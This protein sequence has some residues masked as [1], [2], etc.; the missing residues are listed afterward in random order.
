MFDAEAETTPARV[1]RQV[2]AAM[3]HCQGTHTYE[4]VFKEV[5]EGRLRLW[6]GNDCVAITEFIQF[7]R[8]RVLNVFL[9]A[10]DLSEVPSI[11]PGMEAFARGGGAD[12]ITYHGKRRKHEPWERATGFKAVASVLWRDL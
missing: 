5:A 7:P 12:A 3:E 8:R 11:L 6:I 10:G 2:R 1:E 4:D 9:A